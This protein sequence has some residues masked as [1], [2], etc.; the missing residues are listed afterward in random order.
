M[1]PRGWNPGLSI[2]GM[3]GV[4]AVYISKFKGKKRTVRL[5]CQWSLMERDRCVSGVNCFSVS[6]GLE[7]V[8]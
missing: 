8:D 4:A 3:P 5:P 2:L 1:W 7:N 6:K